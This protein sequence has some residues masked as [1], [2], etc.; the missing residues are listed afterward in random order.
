MLENNKAKHFKVIS[1][2]ATTEVYLGPCHL[3]MIVLLRKYSTT[4][5]H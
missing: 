5:H 4:E 1:K 2:T 3:S